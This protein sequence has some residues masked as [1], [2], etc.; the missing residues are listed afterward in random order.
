MTRSGSL[1]VPGSGGSLPSVPSPLNVPSTRSIETVQEDVVEF[2]DE[3][4]DV[5]ADLTKGVSMSPVGC[6]GR[7]LVLAALII[8]D[9][10]LLPTAI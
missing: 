10:S 1:A 2:E 9:S 4:A 8:A 7:L 6:L 5:P 3:A